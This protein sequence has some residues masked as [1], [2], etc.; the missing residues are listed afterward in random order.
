[1]PPSPSDPPREDRL[2]LSAKTLPVRSW[3]PLQGRAEVPSR[4]APGSAGNKVRSCRDPR[5]R[6]PRPLPGPRPLTR[7]R[8]GDTHAQLARAASRFRPRA[9][10]RCGS[11]EAGRQRWRR[12]AACGGPGRGE[13]S[14]AG[15][16]RTELGRE[17]S[18]LGKAPSGLGGGLGHGTPGAASASGRAPVDP[19]ELAGG[20]C[21]SGCPFGAF[22][23]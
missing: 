13:G 9:A 8:G 23:L 1:M 5:T 12:R 15:P 16:R 7:P 22:G 2:H 19:S 10:G 6:E 21:S 17:A 18:G 3:G 20:S 14:G 11:G 4:P